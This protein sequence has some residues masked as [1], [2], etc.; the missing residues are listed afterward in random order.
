MVAGTCGKVTQITI[1]LTVASGQPYDSPPAPHG[2]GLAVR[3]LMIHRL[4]IR[5]ALLVFGLSCSGAAHA[6]V[7]E[8]PA[9]KGE[10]P[11]AIEFGNAVGSAPLGLL[12]LSVD[13][14]LSR[15]LT[16]AAGM[17]YG[18]GARQVSAMAR[19]RIPG[20]STS[21]GAIMHGIGVGWSMGRRTY[22]LPA[23]CQQQGPFD[24]QCTSP[25]DKVWDPA[26]RVDAEYSIELPVVASA[27]VLRFFGGV[28][29]IINTGSYYCDYM[30]G[31]TPQCQGKYA[32]EGNIY[33][34]LGVGLAILPGA[35]TRNTVSLTFD[36]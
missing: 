2:T 22:L 32:S 5:I 29:T 10:R 23:P 36:E 12:N 27:L 14:A 28:S 15:Y 30:V 31:P 20:G 8:I 13:F 35:F 26:Q 18:D 34:Y 17:G 3:V 24:D 4:P 11:F 9:W 33:P 16:L 7:D 21:V 25:G 19:V 6:Q 1:I